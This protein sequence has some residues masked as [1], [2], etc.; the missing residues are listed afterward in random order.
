MVQIIERIPTMEEYRRLCVSVDWENGIN[1]EIAPQSLPKS[2]F[3]VVAEVDD[4]AIGMER[5]VGDDVMYF[6]CQDIVVEPDYQR[7][8]IGRQLVEY[9][10]GYIKSRAHGPVFVGLFST[11][12]AKPLYESFGF[13]VDSHVEGM[14]HIVVRE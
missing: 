10:L 2:L 4:K 8:G 7:Q 12:M 3:G 1:F 5:I 14:Y 11:N 9:L 6:Y 13:K